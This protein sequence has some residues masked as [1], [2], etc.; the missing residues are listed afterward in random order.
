MKDILCKASLVTEVLTELGDGVAWHKDRGLQFYS[1]VSLWGMPVLVQK[2]HC[3]NKTCHERSSPHHC[4]PK[5]GR[6]TEQE[7]CDTSCARCSAAAD[8]GLCSVCRV[9][10]DSA[11]LAAMAFDKDVVVS[12]AA[13]G[14]GL[15]RAGDASILAATAPWLASFLCLCL[16]DCQHG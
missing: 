13:Q 9:A 3:R 2:C 1:K 12:Q 6:A 10:V 4:V 11:E 15:W 5:L 8:M 7:Q 16:A 14:A